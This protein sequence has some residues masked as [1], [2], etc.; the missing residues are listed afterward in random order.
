MLPPVRTA[1]PRPSPLWLAVVLGACD[2]PPDHHLT[3]TVTDRGDLLDAAAE[4]RLGALADRLRTDEG[5]ELAVLTV[6]SL[7]M[8]PVVV[9][10]RGVVLVVSRSAM[11]I[12][13]APELDRVI[14]PD[15]A[16]VLARATDAA[17]AEGG[18]EE[19]LAALLDAIGRLA[20]P[21]R[22]FRRMLASPATSAVITTVAALFGGT[23]AMG[24]G[25]A[26]RGTSGGGD[27]AAWLRGRSFWAASIVGWAG[28]VA[29]V[30]S[31]THAWGHWVGGAVAGIAAVV[32]LSWVKRV[33]G[34]RGNG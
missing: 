23:W 1:L 26:R 22:T 17:L 9:P 20:A 34:W 32:A 33:G 4:R 21:S 15:E 28:S 27:R 3:G 16:E 29:V 5:I 7:A 30:Q 14:G 13:V 12:E 10:E 18:P 2:M 25:W 19:S 24:A 11:R 31:T 8:E 6:D